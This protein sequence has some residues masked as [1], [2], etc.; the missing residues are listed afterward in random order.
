MRFKRYRLRPIHEILDR[1]MAEPTA[2]GRAVASGSREAKMPNCERTRGPSSHRNI[3][4]V[5]LAVPR[6]QRWVLPSS[7]EVFSKTS[8]IEFHRIWRLHGVS[9]CHV[10]TGKESVVNKN[11]VFLVGRLVADPHLSYT[12]QGSPVGNFSVAVNRSVR[13]SD[14]GWKDDLDGFFDCELWGRTAVTLAED[15]KKGALVQLTGSLR[16]KSWK[17]RGD[18]PR[19]LSKVEIKVESIAP[20]VQAKKSVEENRE[21]PQPQAQPA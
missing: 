4:E 8:Q 7:L 2:I 20:V 15:F 18:Q 21:Q 10:G 3:S 19:T 12:S 14:G 9:R 5:V 6:R 16:Q 11:L 17:T 1:Q 13:K